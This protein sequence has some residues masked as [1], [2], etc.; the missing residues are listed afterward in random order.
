[1]IFKI[2]V[3]MIQLLVIL[4]STGIGLIVKKQ[5]KLSVSSSKYLGKKSY[6]LLLAGLHDD[7]SI[8]CLRIRSLGIQTVI[9]QINTDIDFV[10][11]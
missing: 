11:F 1:M 7:Q 2:N 3:E 8:A 9:I 4:K 10:L 6:K 5:K